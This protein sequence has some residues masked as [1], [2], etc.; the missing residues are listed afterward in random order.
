MATYHNP[1]VGAP[2]IIYQD[3]EQL[4]KAL[5]LNWKALLRRSLEIGSEDFMPKHRMENKQLWLFPE[6]DTKVANKFERWRAER[7]YG[8]GFYGCVYQTFNPGVV[9]KLTLDES[10]VRLAYVLTQLPGKYPRGVVKYFGVYQLRGL[11]GVEKDLPMYALWREEAAVVGN[12][13]LDYFKNY[14]QP[15]KTVLDDL[16]GQFPR[17]L[18]RVK[19]SGETIFINVENLMQAENKTASQKSKILTDWWADS[20]ADD[21]LTSVGYR[22]KEYD[23]EVEA[24]RQSPLGEYIAEFFDKVLSEGITI[25]DAHL[26]NVGITSANAAVRDFHLTVTDPGRAS[27]FSDRWRKLKPPMI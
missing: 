21:P 12:A 10:E 9:F 3:T 20:L 17:L 7:E 8:C 25:G 24:L 1:L 14:V 22:F 23:K 11:Y 16:Y 15:H 2:E 5:E 13:T 27:F 19:N 6:L 18:I 26:G 4:A